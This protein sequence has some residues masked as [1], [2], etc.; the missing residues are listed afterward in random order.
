MLKQLKE[1]YSLLT[2]QQRKRLLRLQLLVVLMAVVELGSVL[3]IGPFMALVGDMT[4]LQRDG[5]V[6]DIYRISGIESPRMFMIVAGLAVLFS[7]LVA[8]IISI[9]TIWCLS[10]YG[11][12][13]GAE[14]SS[15]LYR[16]YMHQPW[17]FHAAGSSSQLTNQIAQECTRLCK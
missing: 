1:L 13:V 12:I 10:M 7:L 15:R 16:H 6:G 8:A 3:S 14:L 11:S 17:L 4:I 5:L 9:L 2:T